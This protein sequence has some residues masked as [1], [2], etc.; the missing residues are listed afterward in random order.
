MGEPFAQRA[1][2]RDLG[3]N[4]IDLFGNGRGCNQVAGEFTIDAL[5]VNA[6]QVVEGLDVTFT[7][8]CE[9]VGPTVTGSVW[10]NS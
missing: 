6:N 5:E 1:S 10:F 4:G 8:R 7:L 3:R 2:F 9:I